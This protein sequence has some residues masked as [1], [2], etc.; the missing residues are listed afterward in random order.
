MD[1]LVKGREQ[2][3]AGHGPNYW[4]IRC[5]GVDMQPCSGLCKTLLICNCSL[6]SQAG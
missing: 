1:V 6:L 4:D 2:S 3:R 5:Y